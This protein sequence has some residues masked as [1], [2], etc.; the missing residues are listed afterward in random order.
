MKLSIS[1][2][3][4][5]LEHLKG[6]EPLIKNV[7][8]DALIYSALKIKTTA[9]EYAPVDTGILRASISETSVNN[10]QIKVVSPVAYAKYQ[11]FGTG[12]YSGGGYITPKTS[13]FLIWKDRKTGK[14]I[15]AKRVKGVKPK[16]FFGKAI[17]DFVKNINDFSDFIISRVRNYFYG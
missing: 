8:R 9:K 16:R 3:G 12:I 6:L 1:I 17:E 11:E 15:F 13:R 14:L 4:K 10:N 7:N 5:G 2:V